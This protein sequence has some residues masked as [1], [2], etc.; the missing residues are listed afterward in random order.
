MFSH[1]APRPT[2]C[3]VAGVVRR[4]LID[5]D[6]ASDDAVALI[7]ALRNPDIHIEAITV[8]AGNVPLDQA[9]QNALYTVELCSDRT[10]VFAGAHAPLVQPLGTAQDVHGQDGMGDLGLPLSGRRPATGDAVDVIIDTFLSSPGQIEL[11]TL[12]E[13]SQYLLGCSR[14][15]A[16]CGRVGYGF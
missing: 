8:V 14:S 6:T 13:V 5:S 10:P 16:V 11:V 2:R 4:I 1:T 7:M 9:V 3:T 15:R 12:E